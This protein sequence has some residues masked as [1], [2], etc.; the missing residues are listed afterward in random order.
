MFNREL[1][2]A[3]V[4]LYAGAVRD[5]Y[6]SSRMKMFRDRCFFNGHIPVHLNKQVAFLVAGPLGQLP[7]LQEILQAS[8]EMSGPTWRDRV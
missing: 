4:T 5:R 6:L 7:N 1:R 3:D 8:A 2:D